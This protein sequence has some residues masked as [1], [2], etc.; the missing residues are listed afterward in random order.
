MNGTGNIGKTQLAA[1]GGLSQ[2]VWRNSSWRMRSSSSSLRDW[3]PGAQ[4]TRL[5]DNG[6]PGPDVSFLDDFPHSVP[7]NSSNP[8]HAAGCARYVCMS[9]TPGC[10]CATVSL[11][12]AS[13]YSVSTYSSRNFN[14]SSVNV[15]DTGSD[16]LTRRAQLTH[17]SRARRM[18]PAPASRALTG[19]SPAMDLI[20]SC[21]C[22]FALPEQC[23]R[24]ASRE[25]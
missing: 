19:G 16:T 2:A 25:C 17:S 18:R 14:L 6:D 20:Q 5:P 22:R 15:T 8:R 23:R 4:D 3:A 1:G 7:A 10:P 12:V 24:S 21:D 9:I 13:F 11:I